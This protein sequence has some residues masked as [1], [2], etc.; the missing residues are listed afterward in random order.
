MLF[1]GLAKL[2][3]AVL[4]GTFRQEVD[5]TSAGLLNPAEG[6]APVDE[7]E[8]FDAVEHAVAGSPFADAA[9]GFHLSF[10]HPCRSHF[11]TVDFHVFEQEAGYH[12]LLVGH[13]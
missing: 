11:D 2:F 9:Y 13:E 8:H 6:G 3:A 10:R 1:G 4:E 5:D 12:E 7:A